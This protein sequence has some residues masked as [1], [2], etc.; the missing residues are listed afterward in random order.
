L[1]VLIPSILISFVTEN[2]NRIQVNEIATSK[3]MRQGSNGL[4]KVITDN[5]RQKNS[6]KET[7]NASTEEATDITRNISRLHSEQSH[8]GG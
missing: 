4:I 3:E 2:Q 7:L 1:F 5:S 8:A 6:T